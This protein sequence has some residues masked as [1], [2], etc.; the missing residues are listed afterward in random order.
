MP[1]ALVDTNILLYAISTA[2]DE[3]DKKRMARDI[4]AGA[5]WGVSIQV[6]HEFYVNATRAA[7]PAMR[8]AEAVAAIEQL[9]LRPVVVNDQLML[10]EALRLKARYGFS[11]WDASVVAAAQRLGAG[12]LYSE[13]MNNGQDYDGVRVTNPFKAE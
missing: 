3:V 13:E 10:R 4:L 6:L 12:T 7:A 9:L 8:H 11:F 2:A 1:A 5:E